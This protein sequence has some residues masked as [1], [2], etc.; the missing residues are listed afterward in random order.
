MLLFLRV[1]TVGSKNFPFFLSLEL[2]GFPGPKVDGVLDLS[3][4]GCTGVEGPPNLAQR[5]VAGSLP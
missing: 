1:F 5:V 4:D 3:R 2:Q